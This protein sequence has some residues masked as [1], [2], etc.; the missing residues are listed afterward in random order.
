MFPTV[1]QVYVNKNMYVSTYKHTSLQYYLRD[2]EV[3]HTKVVIGLGRS[4]RMRCLL[5]K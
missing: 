5:T 3:P 1:Q 2:D 4:T